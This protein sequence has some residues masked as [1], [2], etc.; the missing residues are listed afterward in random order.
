MCCTVHP[1][2]RWARL[3]EAV[4]WRVTEVHHEG[5]LVLA[6]VSFRVAG[7]QTFPTFV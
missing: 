6:K 5:A 1:F 2:G 3:G 7:V 4:W